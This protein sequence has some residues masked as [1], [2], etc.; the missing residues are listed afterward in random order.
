MKDVWLKRFPA[1]QLPKDVV[2]QR[3]QQIGFEGIENRPHLRVA[4]NAQDA[5]HPFDILVVARRFS[6]ASRDGSFKENIAIADMTASAI[7]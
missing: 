7:E 1:L 6:K 3:P 5:K 4:G 2:K